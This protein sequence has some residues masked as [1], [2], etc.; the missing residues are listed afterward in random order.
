MI[1]Y[2]L[3]PPLPLFLAACAEVLNLLLYLQLRTPAPPLV[4]WGLFKQP[5]LRKPMQAVWRCVAMEY[6]GQYVPTLW[7]PLGVR[8]MLRWCVTSWGTVEPSTPY[9]R[10]GEW[11]YTTFVTVVI[12]FRMANCKRRKG[13]S[14]LQ[15]D[16]CERWQRAKSTVRIPM[17]QKWS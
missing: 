14:V 13:R 7:P 16:C 9:H 3:C 17:T 1:H 11:M 6:G 4:L 10:I 12:N 5:P 15:P 8:T 2:F